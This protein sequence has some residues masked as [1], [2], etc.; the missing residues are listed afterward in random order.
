MTLLDYEDILHLELDRCP[1]ILFTDDVF[2]GLGNVKV[3][4]LLRTFD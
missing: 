3:S 1:R 4:K 2:L